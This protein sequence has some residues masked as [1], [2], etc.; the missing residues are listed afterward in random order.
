MFPIPLGINYNNRLLS[1]Q[2]GLVSHH[3]A[4]AL[5]PPP[6][7][8]SLRSLNK[9]LKDKKE[10]IDRLSEDLTKDAEK[11]VQLERRIEVG[12][13]QRRGRCNDINFEYE[14]WKYHRFTYDL[15]YM[16]YIDLS[17]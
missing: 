7:V 6:P 13:R 14:I 12:R 8:H 10:Q 4:G 9:Q 15:H 5:T 3:W 11:K 17:M 1:A 2:R 16:L